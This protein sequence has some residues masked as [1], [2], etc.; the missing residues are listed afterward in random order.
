MR[1]LPI[2]PELE[3]IL[4]PFE[5]LEENE[6]SLVNREKWIHERRQETYFH[7]RKAKKTIKKMYF[8]SACHWFPECLYSFVMDKPSKAIEQGRFD[9]KYAGGRFK[10]TFF[11]LENG[12]YFLDLVY[13]LEGKK[14][15]KPSRGV[16]YEQIMKD[17]ANPSE[18]YK[19]GS[20]LLK[21]YS[22]IWDEVLEQKTSIKELE[23]ID[24]IM[25]NVSRH[26]F[27]MLLSSDSPGTYRAVQKGID[28]GRIRITP[29]GKLDFRFITKG[30]L[31]HIF[32]TGGYT[33]WSRVKGNV[34]IDGQEI[35]GSLKNLAASE[36]PKDFEEIKKEL[37]PN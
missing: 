14:S 19:K 1:V 35:T 34:L 10:K 3:E 2:P 21:A 23:N 15:G 26:Y 29:E 11:F 5:N 25:N 24:S 37:Y 17:K 20:V 22:S 9:D 31:A 27:I 12:M 4:I 16:H 8:Y 33:D 13:Y 7:S 6:Y 32:K 36:P 30:T 18:I 28:T